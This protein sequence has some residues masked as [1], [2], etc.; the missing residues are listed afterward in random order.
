MASVLRWR[1]RNGLTQ[2]DAAALLGVSQPYLSLLEK[3]ERPLTAA[4]QSRMRS[5]RRGAKP[6][7]SGESDDKLQAQFGALGYPGFAH[8]SKSPARVRPD[9]LLMRVLTR[10]DADARV[11]DALPWLVQTHARRM[12]FQRLTQQAKLHNLQNRLGF[13]LAVAEVSSRKALAA[14]HE[15]DRAR[16][17]TEDTLCWDSMPG[18]TREWMRAHRTK[19]AEHWN[20]LTRMR[21]ED[22]TDAA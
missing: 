22:L 12:N 9:E 19:L 7:A 20:V 15:L 2:V 5:M 3:G 6:G 18:A 4:L 1:K 11:V 13:L 21:A 10:P 16:L 8:V 17:L 14:L